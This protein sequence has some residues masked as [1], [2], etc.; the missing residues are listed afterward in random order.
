MAA[1]LP[2]VRP[3]THD[4]LDAIVAFGAAHVPTHY[5]PIIGADAAHQQVEL[6]WTHDRLGPAVATG[7]RI[8]A[9]AGGQIVGVAERGEWQGEPVI[10]KLYVH[11]EHRGRGI[12]RTLLHA[13][14]DGLPG[15]PRRIVLEH[16][17]GNRRAAAF[18]E[19]EGFVHLRTDPAA[20]GDP[21]AATVWR[22]RDLTADPS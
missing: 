2:V 7:G 8:V 9:E 15:S 10:W 16:F 17:A 4:D 12:G 21:A 13:V 5:A 19:R 14:I 18:Y 22:A 11:P 20:N 1:D 3:A 6:W